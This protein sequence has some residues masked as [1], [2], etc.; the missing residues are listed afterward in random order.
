MCSKN[1][2]RQKDLIYHSSHTVSSLKRPAF[3]PVKLKVAQKKHIMPNK[4]RDKG[5]KKT[6]PRYSLKNV[7]NQSILYLLLEMR[8]LTKFYCKVY[9]NDFI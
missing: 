4:D 3:M 9:Y 2:L 1:S 7:Q 8:I 5:K 6:K